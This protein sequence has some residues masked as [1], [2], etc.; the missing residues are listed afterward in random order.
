MWY[1]VLTKQKRGRE[2]CKDRDIIMN[3]PVD[4]DGSEKWEEIDIIEGMPNPDGILCPNKAKGRSSKLLGHKVC[5][6]TTSPQECVEDK[7]GERSRWNFDKLVS[8]HTYFLR[9][10][11]IKFS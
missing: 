1:N 2:L 6:C 7:G 9:V 5:F 10:S 8:H 3:N 11:K 4:Y